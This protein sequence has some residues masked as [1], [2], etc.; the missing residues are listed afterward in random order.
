MRTLCTTSKDTMLWIVFLALETRSRPPGPAVAELARGGDP[1]TSAS[2]IL[3]DCDLFT[4][5]GD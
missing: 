5:I 4:C 3:Q 1:A 2:P